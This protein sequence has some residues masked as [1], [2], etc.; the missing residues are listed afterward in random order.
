MKHGDTIPGIVTVLV[1]GASLAYVSTQPRM[2]V[3]TDSSGGSLGPGF[4]PVACSVILVILGIALI[5]RGIRQGGKVRYFEMT[6]EKKANLRT[7][8]L[9]T[10]MCILFL[11]AWKLTRKFL[12]C[13]FVYSIVINKLLKRSWVFTIIFSVVLT[14]FVYCLFDLGFSVTFRV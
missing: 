14:A 8:A 9:V 13:L 5:V 10:G 1:G 12:V 11:V 6:P 2:T 7:V 3:L 4:F